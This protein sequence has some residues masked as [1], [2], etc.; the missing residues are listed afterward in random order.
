VNPELISYLDS[1]GC[2]FR[3]D[4]SVVAQTLSQL[5]VMAPDI[6]VEFYERYEG[7][8]GSDYTGFMLLELTGSDEFSVAGATE[9]CRSVHGFLPQ[10]LVISD[11]VGD[12]LLVYDCIKDTVHGVDFEGSDELLKSGE[13]EPE[14]TSFGAFL[15][16]YFLGLGWRDS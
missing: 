7:G 11:L 9:I 1:K 3:E 2:Y 13:L 12:G 10:H 16:A 15:D 5:G 4:F 8:F 14:W 6:F